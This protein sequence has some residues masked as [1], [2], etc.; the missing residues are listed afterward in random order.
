MENDVREARDAL[1]SQ[2]KDRVASDPRFRDEF[3]ADPEQALNASD[4][5][6]QAEELRSAMSSDPPGGSCTWTC[7]WTSMD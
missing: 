3:F 2:I 4:L 7:P 1:L 5:S 6:P